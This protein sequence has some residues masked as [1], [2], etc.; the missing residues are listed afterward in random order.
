MFVLNLFLL[1]LVSLA[2]ST[3]LGYGLV[4]LLLPAERGK[5]LGSYQGLMA[6]LLG[7]AFLLPVGYYGVTTV[8][9]LRQVLFVAL[10]LGTLLNALALWRC[11][12]RRL[13]LD[14]REHGWAVL[15][16]GLAFL[17][18]ILP[19]LNYG[20]TTIIGENWD[21]E[22]YLPLAEYLVRAPVNG[23]ASMPPSPLRDLN[24]DPTRI[25]VT[26]GFSIAQGTWQQLAGQ[27]ALRSFAPT[28]ALLRAL[29]VLALYLLFR[30]AFGMSRRAALPATALV[31][32]YAL[33]LWLTF[34]NFGMQLSSL[35]LV[36]LGLLLWIDLL[37]RPGWRGAVATGLAVTAL[38]VSYYPA[39]T[40]FF[41]L[42]G[43]LALV[44]FLLARHRRPV[45]LAGLGAV[46]CT[47]LLASW[48]ILSYGLNL[49]GRYVQPKAV[50]WLSR[51][52]SWPEVLGLVPFALQPEG[53]P[54]LLEVLSGVALVLVVLLGL[55]ALVRSPWRWPWLAVGG[56]GLLYLLWLQGAFFPPLSFFRGLGLSIP[57]SVLELF[58]P[59]PY[60]YPKMAAYVAPFLLGL[61]AQGLAE[62][63][64]PA[65]RWGCRALAV[66][67]AAAA[68]LLLVLAGRSSIQVIAHYWERPAL[69]DRELLRVEEATAL[70]PAG[71]VVYLTDNLER[72]G[73]ATGLLAYFFRD[74]PLR[75]TLS[76]AYSS[77]AHCLPGEAF[78]YALLDLDDNPY[79]LGLFPEDRVWE[80][81]G[82]VL[83][84]R[85]PEQ[86]AFLD[87]R[88][89]ACPGPEAQP[90]FV[91]APLTAQRLAASGGCRAL[92]PGVPLALYAEANG[93]SLSPAVGGDK[94]ARAL[95]LGWSAER[96]LSVRMRWGDG[97]DEET[98]LPAG[99]SVY[100]SALHDFPATVEIL[101]DAG[102]SL[103]W[104]AVVES[105]GP[106]VE[107]VPR[108]AL[109][110]SSVRVEGTTL[111]LEARLYTPERR[112]LQAALEV[113][114]NDY[115]EAT[116]YAW[117]GPVA[118]TPGGV[119]WK[120][121]LQ[122]REAVLY[123]GDSVVP[124]P[125]HRGQEVWPAVEEGTYFVSM[126][127]YYGGQALQALPVALFDWRGGQVQYLSAEPVSS[128]PLY[129]RPLATPADFRF[130][131][132]LR[133]VAYER[134]VGPFAPDEVLPLAVEWR[135]EAP[136]G[137]NYAVTAQVIADG[138]LLGQV[139][140]PVGGESHPT[141]TWRRG[142]EVR[143]DLPVRISPQAAGGRYRLILAVYDPGTMQRLPVYTAD[144]EALG[145]A[146]D[147]GEV[148]VGR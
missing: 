29:S 38:L 99:F 28:L 32:L 76:S 97:R 34:F 135:A 111:F 105:A 101:G 127:V 60:A 63:P 16:A 133:L 8:L 67:T 104:A 72:I 56:A 55:W 47:L 65:S 45:F 142:E 138:R 22:A 113:W 15:L 90:V 106:R 92:N 124:L 137:A 1:V 31:S 140:L 79:L 11:R 143:E 17:L 61:A 58:R 134:P 144:G 89:G 147:L 33:S 115:A 20:Y 107:S 96:E 131:K 82:M 130:G 18:G 148:Q 100:R 86:R 132:E 59:Y 109:L 3:Y 145:D 114:E 126:W 73:P 2:F 91:R 139:D 94:G 53:L 40:V 14:W 42:A 10:G 117:W 39:L 98:S 5:G 88:E 78:P 119:A 70:V 12:D 4:K 66:V 118:L 85:N 83:Y 87:L 80:S 120:V 6:P 26:L 69:F 35:P 102:V 68:L 19:L 50:G 128:V 46:A 52:I 25:A 74:H 44:E 24:A 103:C 75:G 129:A 125:P 48:P 21:T 43:A 9:N 54:G 81:G 57:E 51:I 123:I 136:A 30:Y 64:R 84:R 122:E 36:P 62:M 116:H 108:T 37:R 41:P 121:H 71:E 77:M 93:L 110:S 49:A 95:L 112:T 27:D 146:L 7:Y 13:Y 23:I 141:T